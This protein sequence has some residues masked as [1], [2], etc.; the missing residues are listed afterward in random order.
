M[1]GIQ[2]LKRPKSLN[3][4]PAIHSF[5]SMPTGPRD[6]ARRFDPTLI[7]GPMPIPTDFVRATTSGEEWYL[8]WALYRVLEPSEDPREPPYSGSKDPSKWTY[9]SFFDQGRRAL[10]GAVVD[11]VIFPYA[12]YNSI[13]IRLQTE[14]FHIF[15]D[16]QKHTYDWKQAQ[17]LGKY[18]EVY[19]I[20]SQQIVED[21]TGQS[22]IMAVKDCLSGRLEPNP[23]LTGQAKRAKI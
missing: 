5:P 14:N 8:Y 11:F 18:G 6:F 4:P 3:R 9:Q 13:L 2:E 21:A 12:D 22:A 17:R 20:F 10:G 23:L 19:D 15:T 7:G 1:R 16:V